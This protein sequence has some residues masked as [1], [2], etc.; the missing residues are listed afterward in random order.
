MINVLYDNKLE[1]AKINDDND[2][3]N[4][5]NNDWH[6][7]IFIKEYCQGSHVTARYNNRK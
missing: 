4:G 7:T 3:G 5:G 2:D 1:N 6:S